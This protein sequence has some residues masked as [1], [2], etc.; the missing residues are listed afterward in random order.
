MRYEIPV[1]APGALTGGLQES[2]A[3]VPRFS[4]PCFPF[5][6]SCSGDEPLGFLGDILHVAT[7]ISGQTHG[8]LW[9]LSMVL[10]IQDP[11]LCHRRQMGRRL[12]LWPRNMT[13][14]L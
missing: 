2:F 5:P 3:G 1:G 11:R 8:Q 4:Q 10:V 14:T 7:G 9:L 13:L 6:I 12:L